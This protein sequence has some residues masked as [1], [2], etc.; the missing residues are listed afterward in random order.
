M[1]GMEMEMERR[2]RGHVSGKYAYDYVST[3]LRR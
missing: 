3:P 1:R 2:R